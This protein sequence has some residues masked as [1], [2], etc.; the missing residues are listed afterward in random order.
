MNIR[1]E[2]LKFQTHPKQQA[3]HIAEFAAISDENFK[4]LMGC[5]LGENVILTQ[6][7]A[8]SITLAASKNKAVIRPYIGSLVAQLTRTEV[9]DAVIRNSMRILEE[10]IIPEEFHGEVL[11]TCFEFIQKRNTP[12][13]IKAFSLNVLFNLSN[14][15]PEIKNELKIIILR[16]MDYESAAF[17]SRA[18]KILANI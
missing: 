11:N 9:H 14:S 4:E 15:Y 18:K 7:A 2:L 13:A 6:R 12:I 1:Q 10:L 3:L 5:F 8:W 17:K 16:N